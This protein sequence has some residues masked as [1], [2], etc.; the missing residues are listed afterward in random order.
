MYSTTSSVCVCQGSDMTGRGHSGNPTTGNRK[1]R[2]Q[3]SIL[4]LLSDKKNKKKP[5]LLFLMYHLVIHLWLHHTVIVYFAEHNFP[6]TTPRWCCVQKHLRT[7]CMSIILPVH[8]FEAD[9]LCR[10]W[11]NKSYDVKNYIADRYDLCWFKF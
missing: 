9:H 6:A 3:I 7:Y 8:Q 2:H 5:V 10:L 11:R 1:L 4:Q